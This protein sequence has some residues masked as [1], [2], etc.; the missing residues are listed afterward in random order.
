MQKYRLDN[1]FAFVDIGSNPHRD[2]KAILESFLEKQKH[3]KNNT[4]LQNQTGHWLSREGS[5]NT[6]DKLNDEE[7][8]GKQVELY[9]AFVKDN[10]NHVVVEKLK[11]LVFLDRNLLFKNRWE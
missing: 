6:R 9:K 5:K 4:V 8:K 11:V 3:L 10:N 7:E 2:R 1:A